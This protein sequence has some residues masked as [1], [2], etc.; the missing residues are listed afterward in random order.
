VRRFFVAVPLLGLLLVSSSASASREDLTALRPEGLIVF[1]CPGC[2]RGHERSDLSTIRPDGSGLHDLRGTL[3]DSEPV[4]SPDERRL[5]VTRTDG[6]W[7]RAADGTHG[8]QLTQRHP[9][10]FDAS[11][12]WSPDGKRIVFVRGVPRVAAGGAR[13]GLWI[14]AT[15]GGRPRPLILG[16]GDIARPEWSLSSPDWSPDGRLIAFGREEE[17]LMVVHAD[18]ARPRRLGPKT[19]RGRDPHWSP[20]GHRIAFLEFSEDGR[21][22][23]RFRILDLTTGRTTTVF[24]STGSVWAQSW[25]PDGRRLAIMA[26]QRILCQ[27]GDPRYDCEALALWIVDAL[28]ARRTMIHSFGEYGADVTGIDWRAGR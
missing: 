23:H 17:R 3:G 20:D 19:L 2:P 13:L 28:T 14:V 7:L 11:P 25:S 27:E 26:S 24:K 10:G 16:P 15:Q 22:P 5:A 18:G 6:I 8:R 1:S 12:S 21:P 9:H 4:W